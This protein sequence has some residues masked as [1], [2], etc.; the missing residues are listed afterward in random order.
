M[1]NDA[2]RF[3]RVPAAGGEGARDA[4]VSSVRDMF[5]KLE[6]YVRPRTIWGRFP[7]SCFDG[8]EIGN[9]LRKLL[10]SSR[11]CYLMAVTIGHEADRGIALAQKR[12]MLDG[13]MMDAC[14]SVR[15]DALCDETEAEIRADLK[16][17]ESL[18]ARFSPGYG[19]APLGLSEDVISLL[20]ATRRIGLSMT[21]SLMMTP[22]KSVTAIAGVTAEEPGSASCYGPSG[23]QRCG[24]CSMSGECP[25]RL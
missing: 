12:G 25:Y 11:D 9:D 20:N 16:S 22:V 23:S 14:A 4:L 10:A 3:M 17:G 15:A 21:R 6:L 8:V 2:L 24:V 19:D 7:I 18:T 5:A 1:V 13:M